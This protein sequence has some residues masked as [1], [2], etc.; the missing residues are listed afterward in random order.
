MRRLMFI[1]LVCLIFCPAES[2]A[3]M[4]ELYGPEDRLWYPTSQA[5]YM[6]DTLIFFG[7]YNSVVLFADPMLTLRHEKLGISLEGEGD[8]RCSQARSSAA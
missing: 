1:I 3:A 8:S 4:P 6:V 7:S 5:R 2:F